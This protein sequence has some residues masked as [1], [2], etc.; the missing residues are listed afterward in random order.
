V[1]SYHRLWLDADIQLGSNSVENTEIMQTSAD[2]WQLVRQG[3]FGILLLDEAY[4]VTKVL[5][6]RM[7]PA[8][9]LREL[10][11]GGTLTVYE[12]LH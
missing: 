7:P 11:K 3:G 12:L 4:P 6:E 1:F 10:Y 2:P 8:E 9:K 5:K